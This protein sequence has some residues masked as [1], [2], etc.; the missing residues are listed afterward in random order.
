[1]PLGITLPFCCR[2]PVVTAEFCSLATAIGYHKNAIFV[3]KTGIFR[4]CDMFSVVGLIVA[5]Y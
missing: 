5:N 1:M 4:L 2:R 3:A